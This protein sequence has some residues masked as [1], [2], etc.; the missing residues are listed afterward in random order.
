MGTVS[1]TR[2]IDQQANNHQGLETALAVVERFTKQ[3]GLVVL[4]RP[5]TSD[6]LM[7]VIYA[8]WSSMASE[9]GLGF[10]E[11]VLRMLWTN[12]WQVKRLWHPVST[13]RRYPKHITDEEKPGHFLTSRIRISIEAS[14]DTSEII[15]LSPIIRRLVP[16]NV[17][18]K[19]HS[20][21][22]D[23]ELGDSI[24]GAG[25][26]GRVYQVMDF[27]DYGAVN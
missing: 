14:V 23:V 18:V 12:Q 3:D 25:V 16:A 13:Y 9:R 19:V 21:A 7:R 27:S 8:N 15:E 20:K 5:F 26:Y 17:V 11:F 1:F 24:I 4:R 2:P 6:T 10:L 22:L